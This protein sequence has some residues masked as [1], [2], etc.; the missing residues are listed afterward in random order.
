MTATRSLAAVVI[1]IVPL[2]AARARADEVVRFADLAGTYVSSVRGGCKLELGGAGNY[3]LACAPWQRVRKSQA[4]VLG[5]GW[6]V[7]FGGDGQAAEVEARL[8]L[9]PDP[10]PSGAA[11]WPPS[12]RDP[13]RGP[14]VVHRPG[15][16]DSFLL[17]PM[18]WGERLYLIQAGEVE[19][20]CR[21]IS[22]RVEPRKAAV[23]D[24]FLRLGDH[25]R[26]VSAKPP[27]E[28][29]AFK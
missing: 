9:P 28:C 14:Y 23:G 11:G 27:A 19:A 24:Q 6:L 12:L 26:S 22:S 21:S 4:M 29:G 3:S 1:A 8:S 16:S 20:F 7:I 15:A 5:D 2:A 17:L 10:P 13:T 25:V 18:R